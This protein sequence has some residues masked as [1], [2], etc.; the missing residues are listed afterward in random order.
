[1]ECLE[2]MGWVS[3][4]WDK[5]LHFSCYKNHLDL[6]VLY[7]FIGEFLFYPETE[8]KRLLNLLL[9]SVNKMKTIPDK[10]LE[11]IFHLLTFFSEAD[12][13]KIVSIETYSQLKMITILYLAK[14]NDPPKSKLI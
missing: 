9:Q 11:I 2:L 12:Q 5:M 3:K 14:M 10:T 8:F 13:L 7:Y 6:L 4:I 1:M